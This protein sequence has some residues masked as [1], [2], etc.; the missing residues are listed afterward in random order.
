MSAN[1]KKKVAAKPSWRDGDAS[2]FWAGGLRAMPRTP[3]EPAKGE[4]RATR[5]LSG[6]SWFGRSETTW[7]RGKHRTGAKAMKQLVV[8]KRRRENEAK[9]D[10]AV[11]RRKK[12]PRKKKRKT[13]GGEEEDDDDEERQIKC[14]KWRIHPDAAQ[15]VVLKLWCDAARWVYNRGA[16]MINGN[17]RTAR[18]SALRKNVINEKTWKHSSPP[19]MRAV[20]YEIKDSP[21]QD[22]VKAVKAL[23]AKEKTF[24]RKL[25]FRASD[26]DTC[27]VTLRARQL[28][29]KRLGGPWGALFGTV[30]DRS[31]MRTED[32]KTLPAVFERDCRLLRERKTGFYWLCIPVTVETSEEERQKKSPIVAIDP[33]IRTFATCYGLRDRKASDWG[34]SHTTKIL[35]WLIR[36]ASRLE[37]KAGEARGRH[38][39]RIAAVAARI[40]KRST[41]L[42]TEL[43]RKCAIWLCETYDV[44]LLP[45]FD[46]KQMAQRKNREDGR[47]RKI[48]KKTAGAMVRL[49]HYKFRSFLLHKA[50]QTG[51]VVELCDENWTSKTCGRCGTLNGKL[52]SS[53][54]FRCPRC[55]YEADRDHNAARNILIRYAWKNEGGTD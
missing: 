10:E 44:V 20:P 26:D 22:L 13:E 16:K 3:W 47:A 2:E 53:K 4:E 7:K 24:K 11:A 46:T 48:G 9:E 6:G 32:G 42:V 5:D 41:D 39:K 17:W 51:T 8:E 19:R 40:R 23:R 18:L 28:N 12:R 25:E 38:R 14:L 50:R 37:K 21:L 45:K 27:S 34:C 29:C 36:K 43:H 30:R 33:G 31:A 35:Y 49:S 15:R 55:A 52:G 54:A 1:K